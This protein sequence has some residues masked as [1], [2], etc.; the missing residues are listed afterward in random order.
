MGGPADRRAPGPSDLTPMHCLIICAGTYGDCFPF[1][2]LGRHLKGRGHRVTVVAPPVYADSP[3]LHGISFQPLCSL[4]DY[5]RF[6][7]DAAMLAGRYGLFFCRD[8]AVH[9]NV[10][11]WR[12]IEA[13]N[14][15]DLLVVMPDQPF[16]W[17]DVAARSQLGCSA[18]RVATF[19][20]KPREPRGLRPQL[21]Y[22]HIQ[23][24]LEATLALHWHEAALEAGIPAG[25]ANL[26]ALVLEQPDLPAAALWPDWLVNE[27]D[28]ERKFHAFGF[29]L[30]DP[31][32]R[33]LP[34]PDIP[35]DIPTMDEYVIFKRGLTD[36]W[37]AR[38][39]SAAIAAC[40]KLGIRGLLLDEAPPPVELPPELI[41][42]RFVPLD[43]ALRKARAIV[44][45]G[46]IGTVA[47]SL[48]CGVPQ[49]I[50]PRW[51]DQ[52]R[53][54]EYMRRLGVASVIPAERFTP[55]MLCLQIE[56][57]NGS[58]YRKRSLEVS[59]RAGFSA[60][61]TKVCDFLEG[62]GSQPS[63]GSLSI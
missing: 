24:H 61:A 21:P 29:L 33:P 2:T 19:L 9:W 48:Q 47:V 12:A 35:P 54:A 25:G 20:P 62:V 6:I 28:R 34:E 1:L 17:A 44:Y 31:G 42:R 16:F 11:A 39:Y 52:P 51:F 13:L 7:A 23:K 3:I 57:L 41:W 37:P 27:I 43:R 36:L 45:N 58:Q 50:V 60:D 8:H 55:E 40:R 46:G 4:P 26:R 22:G 49:I 5:E 59:G 32:C 30:P 14:A 63:T 18:V 15:R 38:F 56:R 10:A 53:N